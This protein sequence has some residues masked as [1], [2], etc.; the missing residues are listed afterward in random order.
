[1]HVQ[2]SPTSAGCEE[3]GLVVCRG[4]HIGGQPGTHTLHLAKVFRLWLMH[5]VHSAL[6]GTKFAIQ[7][8]VR[9][10]MLSHSHGLASPGNKVQHSRVGG[11]QR[12]AA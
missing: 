9:I 2:A 5:P 6:A 12:A 8:V 3:E 11:V 1:M 4:G 10:I 7:R